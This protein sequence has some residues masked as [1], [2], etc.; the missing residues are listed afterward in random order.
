LAS[1]EKAF[2]ALND[3]GYERL[4]KELRK[5]HIKPIFMQKPKKYRRLWLIEMPS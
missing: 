2:N 5:R 1:L 3:K 4:R